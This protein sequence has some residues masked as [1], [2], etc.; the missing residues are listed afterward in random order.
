MDR[1]GYNN[2]ILQD[3]LETCYF[4]PSPDCTGGKLDRHEVFGGPLRQKSKRMGLWVSICHCGCHLGPSGVHE[5]KA[6]REALQRAAQFKAMKVYGWS[7][8]DWRKEFYKSYI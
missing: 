6:K 7:V 4:W 2:S 3:D 5:N 8:E 1:N